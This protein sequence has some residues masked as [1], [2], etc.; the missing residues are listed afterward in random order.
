MAVPTKHQDLID[1]IRLLKE[2]HWFSYGF[3]GPFLVVLYP[4]WV[5]FTM[6]YTDLEI[7]GCLI[8][9]AGIGVLQIL[10]VLSC[11]WSVHFL[12][13]MT[14]AEVKNIKEANMALVVPTA[15]NGSPEIVRVQLNRG[16]DQF[17]IIFQNLRFEWDPE[18][19]TFRGLDFPT[20]R[21]VDHYINWK[22]YEDEA[23]LAKAADIYGDNTY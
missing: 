7:E 20:D 13:S 5:L 21:R 18:K 22:G 17:Y 11:L 10:V 12:A 15:N 2:K 19:R 3:V 6:F 16:G 9:L 8:I 4:L 1:R 14:H 23:Q